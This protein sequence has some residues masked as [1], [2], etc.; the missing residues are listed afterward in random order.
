MGEAHQTQEV[1]YYIQ[2]AETLKILKA[3]PPGNKSS[4]NWSRGDSPI[5]PDACKSCRELQGYSFHVPTSVLDFWQVTH[6]PVSNSSKLPD[7]QWW[8]EMKSFH[9][10]LIDGC[11]F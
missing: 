4:N 10:S 2:K 9:W 7:L 3:P 1:D 8:I 6:V 5:S 11:P